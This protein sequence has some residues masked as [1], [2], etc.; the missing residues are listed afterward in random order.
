[1]AVSER[2]TVG[3]LKTDVWPID[4]ILVR[5]RRGELRIPTFQRSFVWTSEDVRDLF[6][7][8]YKGFPIGN[9]LLWSPDFP[10]H[11]TRVEFG[12]LSFPVGNHP[13]L[14]VV[15]G[16]QRMT[17]LVATLLGGGTVDD[18]F[19]VGFDLEKAKF[20]SL[21]A[22]EAPEPTWL[23]LDQ[24]ADTFV[25]LEWLQGRKPPLSREQTARANDA[26]KA[27]RD[28]RVPVYVVHSADEDMAREIFARLNESGHPLKKR[29][30]FGA[31]HR[32]REGGSDLGQ[33]NQRIAHLGWG[34]LDEDWLLKVLAAVD[35]LL[36]LKD[37]GPSEALRSTT[38]RAIH[39]LELTIRFLRDDMGIPHGDL[40]PYRFPILPLVR[41]FDHSPALSDEVRQQLATWIWRGV[42]SFRHKDTSKPTV[43]SAL[44][45][46]AEA[47]EEA[48][49]QLLESVPDSAPSFVMRTH[50]FRAAATKLTCLV[51]LGRSPRHL[52]TGEVLEPS[53]L[54]AGNEP[55]HT[56]WPYI[57]P[58]SSRMGTENRLFHPP[59]EEALRPLMARASTEVLQS[60]LIRESARELVGLGERKA[61]LSERKQ[62][63]EE[64]VRVFL[65]AREVGGQAP[66][67]PVSGGGAPPPLLPSDDL[68]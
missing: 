21:R 41:L 35:G 24:T 51:L 60:H 33:L 47:P 34:A 59:S 53:A 30:V 65:S 29:D 49:R 6:D 44:L 57:F 55:A 31:L 56:F 46:A 15:D 68:S 4:D 12:P 5:A 54:L 17:S 38:E 37:R 67:P 62:D 27:L 10:V 43:R 19:R 63:I 9:L 36:E 42:A 18:R 23:P 2:R 58:G 64:A 52:I 26:V 14:L 25:F 32:D 3:T 45:S 1:M 11:N 40:L 13:P 48:A 61:F 8:L 66:P 50:D 22:G 16:Q 28:Y 39:A 20:T 7:S